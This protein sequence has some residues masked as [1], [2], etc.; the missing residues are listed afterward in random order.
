[1]DRLHHHRGHLKDRMDAVASAAQSV[2]GS[3]A[4]DRY[5]N[6]ELSWLSFNER[7]LA[8]ACNEKYP[9]LERLRF[10][11]ISGS[12]LDE[13]MMIRVAGLAAQVRSDVPN[14]SIDGKTP[15]QQIAS[16]TAKIRELESSQQAILTNLRKLLAAQ[17]IHVSAYDR[18]E[19]E[20]DEWLRDYF[21]T[22]VV[23]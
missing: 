22:H 3:R 8:E 11:S 17:G 10:L 23:P 20:A 14:L 19:G 2:E 12:N 16:I 6:R 13:F 18:I 15:Q 9:L 5:F 21:L 4:E 7:V 1:M